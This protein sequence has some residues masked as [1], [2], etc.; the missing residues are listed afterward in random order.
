MKKKIS[1]ITIV[2]VVLSALI[3]IFGLFGIF[4][5]K[6]AISDLLFTFLTLT[7]AGILTINSCE[8]LERKDKLAIISLSLISL[9]SLLVILCYWT[10]FD[11]SDLYIKATLVISALSICFNLI[12]SSILKMGQNYKS[13][14]I[15]SYFCYSIVT[16]YLILVF[17][18]ISELNG[19]FLKTFI[20]FVILSFLA[21]CIL[22][23]LAKKKPHSEIATKE[24]V[25][26]SKEEYNDLL[27][28]K[29]Q[30]E[31]LLKERNNND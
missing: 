13:I 3:A 19:T 2:C 22:T 23:I 31:I 11:N 8:M 1:L 20:L 14:Q 7:V 5:I 27:A 24:Y 26:I 6:G 29:E 4:K 10:N 30:L 28:K 21:M 9:S 18:N 25:K 17:L 16:L 15:I 12:T